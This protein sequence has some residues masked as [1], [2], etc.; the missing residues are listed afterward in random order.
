MAQEIAVVVL[1]VLLGLATG[2]AGSLLAGYLADRKKRRKTLR[3]SSSFGHL[4][5][6]GTY[7][8]IENKTYRV[9]QKGTLEECPQKAQNHV[10]S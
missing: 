2:A 1:M 4:P 7:V 6:P 8:R 5:P 3:M 10:P 9:G